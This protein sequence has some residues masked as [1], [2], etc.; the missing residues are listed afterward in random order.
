MQLPK[1]TFHVTCAQCL[2]SLDPDLWPVSGKRHK[3][4]N[5]LGLRTSEIIVFLYLLMPSVFLEEGKKNLSGVVPGS[6]NLQAG[7]PSPEGT[8]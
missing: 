1:Q 5:I 8:K 2:P 4:V 7:A 6:L 3:D